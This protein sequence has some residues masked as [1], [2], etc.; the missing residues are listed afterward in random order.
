M[1][2]QTSTQNNGK[3]F[4]I[5]S[6]LIILLMFG[7]SWWAYP[8][9][10]ARVPSHWNAAGEVNGY[11][12]A[13]MGAFLMPAVALGT[14]I[15]FFLIPRIDPRKTNFQQ[16]GKVFWLVGFAVV[17]FLSIL[18]ISTLFIAVGLAHNNLIP[19]I[20][21]AGGGLLLIVIGN[22]MGKVKHNYMFGIRTP[23]TLANEEVW[24]KTHR[25]MGPLWVVGGVILLFLGFLPQAVIMP[26]LFTV[27]IVLALGS[28]AYSYVVFQ[29]VNRG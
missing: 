1:T 4:Q 18:H 25:T 2:E 21:F 3:L 26:V 23:W 24:Y 22:Y 6:A 8:H 20:S 10:P 9:L 11:A 16:M 15:L 13:F 19:V 29:R 28:L 14:W 7:I 17:L 5:L 27:M 12:N